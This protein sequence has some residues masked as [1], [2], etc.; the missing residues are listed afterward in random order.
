[1]II[2]QHSNGVVIDILRCRD[3]TTNEN[4]A[5]VNSIPAYEP[6]EGYNGVLKYGENGLYWDYELSETSD[7]DEISNEEAL[8][9]LLGGAL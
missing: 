5:V 9:I 3:D 1:M 4:I 2:I 6:R 8:N 7:E